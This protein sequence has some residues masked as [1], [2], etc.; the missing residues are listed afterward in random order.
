MK[1]HGKSV[2]TEEDGFIEG[3]FYP[4]K[5]YEEI[6]EIPKN[7]RYIGRPGLAELLKGTKGRKEIGRKAKE[8]LERHGYTQKE[9][10]DYLGIHYTTVSRMVNKGI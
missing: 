3:F 6:E 5:G 7:Q 4:A 10:A 8:A 9:V 2:K 1:Q